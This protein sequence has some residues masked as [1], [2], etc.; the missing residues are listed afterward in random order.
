M[1][2]LSA[3]AVSRV[4]LDGC[5]QLLAVLLAASII[6]LFGLLSIYPIYVP[7]YY[8]NKYH[9]S[10]CQQVVNLLTISVAAFL[11]LF[12]QYCL[13]LIPS[14]VPKPTLLP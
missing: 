5:C 4:V 8:A 6:L 14:V 7:D 12:L 1:A 11:A 2:A 9:V 10:N 13:G 3:M